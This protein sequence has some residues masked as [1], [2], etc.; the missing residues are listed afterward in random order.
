MPEPDRCSCTAE[1]GYLV[2]TQ[3]AKLGVGSTSLIACKPLILSLEATAGIEPA[4]TVLQSA[5]PK[6]TRL[7]RPRISGMSA[8]PPSR[9]ALVNR[10][11][12]SGT[13]PR[14]TSSSL[15]TINFFVRCRLRILIA[16]AD[17]QLPLS[18]D[19]G[20]RL[21]RSQPCIDPELPNMDGSPGRTS[22]STF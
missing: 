5:H 4:Y 12:G 7:S 22:G 9:M 18:A 16:A 11:V 1:S 10:E 8:P 2:G 14:F 15:A 13:G 21:N 3:H 17:R 6:K 20:A 19:Q